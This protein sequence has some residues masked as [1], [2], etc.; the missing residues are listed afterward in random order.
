MKNVRLP[1]VMK[2]LRPYYY[3]RDA[4]SENLPVTVIKW[5]YVTIYDDIKIAIKG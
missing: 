4:F 5:R 2:E 1:I 3:L